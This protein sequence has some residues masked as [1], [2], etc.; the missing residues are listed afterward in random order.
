MKRDIPVQVNHYVS[1][2][3]WK[4]TCTAFFT[5]VICTEIT[6]DNME[7]QSERWR[8]SI[9]Q[10]HISDIK[11]RLKDIYIVCASMSDQSENC[12]QFTDL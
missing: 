11:W 4:D 2:Q 8:A 6:V 9:L 10:V 1:S 3:Y 7:N 5:M 12:P